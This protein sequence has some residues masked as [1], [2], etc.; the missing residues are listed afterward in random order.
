MLL[1]KREIIEWRNQIH[2]LILICEGMRLETQK[3]EIEA[4]RGIVSLNH[5]RVHGN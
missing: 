3:K 1:V 4:I 2:A 5:I